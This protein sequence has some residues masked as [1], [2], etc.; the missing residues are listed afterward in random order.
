M[1]NPSRRQARRAPGVAAVLALAVLAAARPSAAQSLGRGEASILGLDQAVARGEL[2]YA[3]AA[4]QKYFFVFDR[5]RMDE[6]WNLDGGRPA[7]CGTLV[8]EELQQN[9]EQLDPEIQGLV[10]ERA[11]NGRGS[12]RGHAERRRARGETAQE[13]QRP[14]HG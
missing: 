5:T 3:E 11:G 7:K 4:R 1:P 14:G 9:L 8:L 13:T 12:H 6:R 2:S 10:N